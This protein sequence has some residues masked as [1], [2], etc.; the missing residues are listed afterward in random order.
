MYQTNII[1]CTDSSQ[2]NE[3]VKFGNPRPGPSSGKVI[4]INNAKDGR[5]LTVETPFITTWGAKES[6]DQNK[7]PTG[8]WTVSLQ[9]PNQE[10][11]NPEASK[12]LDFMVKFEEKV[13][14][15]ALINASNWLGV[16]KKTSLEV[17]DVMFN[18]MLKYPKLVKGKPE[19]DYNK[20]PSLTGKI[21]FWKEKGW[22]IEVF[23]E[24]MQPLF[25]KTDKGKMV[26]F[27]NKET[28]EEE[29]HE[30]T[31]IDHLKGGILNVKYLLQPTIW[32]TNSKASITWTIVQALVK[33]TQTMRIPEGVCLLKSS[34]ED[35]EYVAYSNDT[36][37]NHVYNNSNNHTV[38]VMVEESDDDEPVVEEP[39]VEEP[40]VEEPVVEEPV[41]EEPVVEKPVVEEPV[42]EKPV[43]KETVVEKPV[44]PVK[45]TIVKKKA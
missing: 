9:F 17:I 27:T 3:I 30:A 31:P 15:T 32:I 14:H 42:V 24:V 25:V 10:Y 4:N 1:D 13:K 23:D 35:K 8:K 44:V 38:N 29:E 16:T 5:T 12:L 41:V 37:D 36:E 28:G 11:P 2:I 6:L 21:P 18:P 43:V 45:K 19:L 22:Q 40:V 39:V 7:L 20:A 26:K 34:N 33:K